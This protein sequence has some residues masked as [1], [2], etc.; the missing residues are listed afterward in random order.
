M[1]VGDLPQDVFERARKETFY[2]VL[3]SYCAEMQSCYQAGMYHSSVFTEQTLHIAKN[4]AGTG[5][6]SSG[7]RVNG[8]SHSVDERISRH[9]YKWHAASQPPLLYHMHNI[10]A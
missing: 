6:A 1:L 7:K 5:T 4:C 2:L 3:P 9:S 10:S 8:R